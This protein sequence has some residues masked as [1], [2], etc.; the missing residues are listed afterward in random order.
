M[1]SQG[2]DVTPLAGPRDRVGTGANLGRRVH[3][4]IPRGSRRGV[5]SPGRHLP[6]RRPISEARPND[7]RCIGFFAP[8]LTKPKDYFVGLSL[9]D[10]DACT[11]LRPR[12]AIS[13]GPRPRPGLPR[14]QGGR[15]V[16]PVRAERRGQ[17]DLPPGPLR[18]HATRPRVGHRV[19]DRRPGRPERGPPRTRDPNR[20]P[21]SLRGGDRP[22]VPLVLRGDGRGAAP[23]DS[24]EGRMD[25]VLARRHAARGQPDRKALH[26][27]APTDGAG[28]GH[29]EHGPDALPRR[30]F[31]ERG[32]EHA[33]RAAVDPPRVGLPRWLHPVH[34]PQP[35]RERGDRRPLRLPAPRPDHRPRDR[36]GIEVDPPRPR[37]RARGEQCGPRP[38][39][40]PG[41]PA[42][43]PRKR[44]PRPRADR[45]RVT[46]RRAPDRADPGR[47]ERRPARDE[48]RRHDGGRLLAAHA[49]RPADRPGGLAMISWEER[50]RLIMAIVDKDRR[51]PVWMW[52]TTFLIALVGF[53]LLL[54]AAL[55]SVSY[56]FRPTWTWYDYNLRPYY[57]VS[58]ALTSLLLGL[59]FAHFHHG[60]VHRGTIRSII[61]YPVDMN[62]ITIAKL[63]SSLIVSAILSTMLFVGVFG[64]F[65]L[66]GAFPLGDFL[67]IH[68]TAL[69][70]SFLALAV[71][72]FLAQAIAHM[73]GRMVISPTAL[74]A[75]FLL[76]SILMTETG[77][78]FLGT[79]V[80]FLMRPSGRGFTI[81]D[82]EAIR[83]IAQ[84]LSVFSPHHV[85]AR[86][87]ALA[88]GITGMWADLHVI[89]P[90]A[91]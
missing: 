39:S 62:D 9:T 23:G 2:G 76:L 78:T 5:P 87:L 11:G 61:L 47:G 33:D 21:V 82:F 15:G 18:T 7:R 24:R 16:R 86:I 46:G 22:A 37:V 13:A 53:F 19:R 74:G 63:V 90:L 69:M 8:N 81:A 12:E 70:M 59:T 10:P 25:H 91:V 60:E 40:P 6:R 79:Q 67:A 1:G 20:H 14:D 49:T 54:P 41:D 55:S 83:T 77:L 88:F 32:C 44:G 73:A 28:P 51:I 45:T 80:A 17:D 89:V 68:V 65:F 64:G 36:A 27:G 72:V 66:V 58:A 3:G 75:I 31:L 50:V 30:T 26:G 84:S 34:E 52:I 56:S 38:G 48:E 35:P 85:G 4:G 42:P 71:G 43:E 57:A 29:A